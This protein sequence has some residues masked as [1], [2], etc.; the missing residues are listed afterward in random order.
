[1]CLITEDYTK[2]HNCYLEIEYA[3]TIGKK[4][5]VLLIEELKI[6][7]LGAVGFIIK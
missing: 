7:D 4:I 3:N 1:M 2:S 5:I 6:E